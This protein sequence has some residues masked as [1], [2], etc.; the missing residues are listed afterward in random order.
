MYLDVVT[1]SNLTLYKLCSK[2]IIN[3]AYVLNIYKYPAANIY[4]YCTGQVPPDTFFREL[5]S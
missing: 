3:L 4:I 1:Q 2:L 5:S